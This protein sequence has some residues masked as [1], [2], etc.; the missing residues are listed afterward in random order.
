MSKTQTYND[1]FSCLLNFF[2][3]ID[4]GLEKC[5][6]HAIFSNARESQEKK[7]ILCVI[8]PACTLNIQRFSLIA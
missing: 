6:L 1:S 8:V 7:S 3:Y 5:F 2:V 4:D